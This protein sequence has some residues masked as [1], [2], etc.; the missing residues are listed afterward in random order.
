MVPGGEFVPPTR[1]FSN[2]S[3]IHGHER[4]SGDLLDKVDTPAIPIEG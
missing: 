2:H 3:S 4:V 1:G